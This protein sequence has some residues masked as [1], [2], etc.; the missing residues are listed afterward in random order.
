MSGLGINISDSFT[1]S[2][3]VTAVLGT[4]SNLS[5]SV[6]DTIALTESISIQMLQILIEIQELLSKGCVSQELTSIGA[7]SEELTSKGSLSQEITSIM[8]DSS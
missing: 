4:I 5:T 7:L 2:E 1:V 3:A 6:S 8:G